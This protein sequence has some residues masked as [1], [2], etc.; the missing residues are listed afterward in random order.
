M[1]TTW[2]SNALKVS[3]RGI[4]IG[5]FLSL[6]PVF[7]IAFQLFRVV[8]S[9]KDKRHPPA[10][11]SFLLNKTTETTETET[12]ETPNPTSI[13]F[14][15]YFNAIVN[16]ALLNHPQ[17]RLLLILDNIDRVDSN[18]ALSIWSTL[19]TFLQE[20]GSH[21]KWFQQ[22]WIL[23]PYD[24][25]GLQKIWS[26]PGS[27][28]LPGRSS[29]DSFID[30]SFQIRF[31]VS[32]PLLSD[33][34]AYLRAIID[35]ALPD[36]SSEDKY[37]I[38]Q[39]YEQWLNDS[40]YESPTPRELK[41]CVNQV[42]AILRQWGDKFPTGHVTYYV[43]QCRNVEPVI[44][45]LRSRELPTVNATKQFGE[46][47]L[48]SLAG[49]AF[50][51][52]PEKGIEL[53]LSEPIYQNL[54]GGFPEKLLK[55]EKEYPDGFWAVFAN[56]VS[57]RIPH[58]DAATLSSASRCLAESNLLKNTERSEAGA[59]RLG[60][61]QAAKFIPIWAPM[62]KTLMQGVISL[63]Q[64]Q[65]DI[66]FSTIIGKAIIESVVPPKFRGV[67]EDAADITQTF[68]LF[69]KALKKLSHDTAIPTPVV[70]PVSA[71]GWLSACDLL[72]QKNEDTS[73]WSCFQP[74]ASPESLTEAVLAAVNAGGFDDKY[75]RA[76]LVTL[77]SSVKLS[78]DQIIVGVEHR[79]G[80]TVTGAGRSSEVLAL[81]NALYALRKAGNLNATASLK[82]LVSEGH[83]YHHF[84]HAG[85]VPDCRALCLLTQIQESPGLEVPRSIGQSIAGHTALLQAIGSSDLGLASNI[86]RRLSEENRLQYLLEF[87]RNRGRIEPIIATCL[88]LV[89]D[90]NS[91][92]ELFTGG[93]LLE[94]W[95]E[96]KDALGDSGN[97]SG[98]NALLAK[99]SERRELFGEI[100]DSNGNFLTK[101]AE[102]YCRI[103]V[104]SRIQDPQFLN[105]CRR[106]LEAMS[107][108]E[109][110]HDLTTDSTNLWLTL[111]LADHEVVAKLTT[112]FSDALARHSQLLIEGKN[113]PYPELLAQ[114]G[115]VFSLIK[116]DVSKALLGRILSTCIEAEGQIQ[117][118]IFEVYGD[119]LTNAQVLTAN[120]HTIS[121]L[122]SPILRLRNLEGLNWLSSVTHTIPNILD[123][124]SGTDN[125][126]EF[127]IR[128]Q[129]CITTAREDGEA[130]TLIDTIA[131]N[132]G[133]GQKKVEPN[134][135]ESGMVS[136]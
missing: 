92:N 96:I 111:R 26:T 29:S 59:I 39:A 44:K 132:L 56:I 136:T 40:G 64:I 135:E 98:F 87:S 58:V 90:G 109:W 74:L 37:S 93:V 84:Q 77:Q 119:Q 125:P 70:L 88:K 106:G 115:N 5:S 67:L 117:K 30:K 13:E 32:P 123:L 101:D 86:V 94:R 85:S 45:R 60:F 34:K 128:L 54:V 7:V 42:G 27:L 11:W 10:D 73:L 8:R 6:A 100:Q 71:N 53:L 38:Y 19:Q 23:V 131:Q 28:D 108:E 55:Q 130:Q 134:S 24:P 49:L 78:W 61:S 99:L 41:L 103:V 52:P 33:W 9:K 18:T 80:A 83:I 72:S 68:I 105:W 81:L 107:E 25:R 91:P 65:D 110:Y 104:N 3:V 102:L 113:L 47:L 12:V 36:H 1:G 129:D 116:P 15:R 66:D 118:P 2:L 97:T 82:R 122:F 89:A 20:R 124:A 14:E 35:K 50:N 112:P 75:Y 21:E 57:I 22:V 4:W 46:K 76:I 95:K 127:K 16:E 31:Q 43:L 114:W 63:C 133:V 69:I 62:D 17:R 120:D 48:E 79:L 51:V 121:G 126:G